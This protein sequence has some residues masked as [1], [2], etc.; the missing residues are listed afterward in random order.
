M[1]AL[2]AWQSPN[3]LAHKWGGGGGPPLGEFNPPPTEGVRSVLDHLLRMLDSCHNSLNFKGLEPLSKS[4]PGHTGPTGAPSQFC[5]FC[6][7]CGLLGRF[8]ALPK[9]SS[10]FTSKKHRKKCKNQAPKSIFEPP[11]TLLEALHRHFSMHL[12]VNEL[13][14]STW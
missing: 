13:A 9:R 10:K 4:L 5:W 14:C 3:I 12:H 7:L 8:F 11:G 6:A 1:Q 2:N